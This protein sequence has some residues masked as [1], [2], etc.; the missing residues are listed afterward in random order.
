[1]A[2]SAKQKLIDKAKELIAKDPNLKPK[3]AVEKARKLLGVEL[4][5]EAD[6]HSAIGSVSVYKR[7]MIKEKEAEGK[8]RAGTPTGRR[9]V[10][11]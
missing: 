4:K 10:G 6:E 9:A 3:A 5:G 2:K 8:G 11:Y 7:D 1:M